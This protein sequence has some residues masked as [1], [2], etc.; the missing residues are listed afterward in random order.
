VS[1]KACIFDL[2]GVISHTDEFHYLAWKKICNEFGFS[3]D[4]NVN[5]LLRGVSRKASF[6]IILKHNG[7]VLEEKQILEAIE[8]KNGMYREFLNT[9]TPADLEPDVLPT[10]Q[11]LKKNGYKV[12]V[13]S[14]SKNAVFILEKLGIF[15]VFDAVAD[16]NCITKSKPDPEV[17][18]KAADMVHA[19]YFNCTVIEDAV[20]GIQAA[21]AANMGAIAFRLCSD[22]IDSSILH[23]DSFADILKILC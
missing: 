7:A 13:G 16:G 1:Q 9:M 12:A 10:L 8:K 21:K 22:E 17:F 14:S 18:I 2:D 5:N 20:S 3:F 6:E 15:N 11:A 23:A 19:D 4:R